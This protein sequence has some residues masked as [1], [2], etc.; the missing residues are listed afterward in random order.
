M[1]SRKAIATSLRRL[2]LPFFP[3]GSS[4]CFQSSQPQ[5]EPGTVQDSTGNP[6]SYVVKMK[7]GSTLTWNR[8]TTGERFDDS[9]TTSVDSL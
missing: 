1:I 7:S 4:A 8:R 5:V 9:D 3:R 2:F 6:R